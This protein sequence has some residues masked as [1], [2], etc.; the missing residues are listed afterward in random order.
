MGPQVNGNTSNTGISCI[1]VFTI[2][3]GNIGNA[4]ISD[5]ATI[6]GIAGAA[7]SQ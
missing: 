4:G 5:F 2:I 3:S 7:H 1:T 6:T